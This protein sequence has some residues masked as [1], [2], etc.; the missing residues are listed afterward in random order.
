MLSRR[1]LPIRFKCGSTHFTLTG[2]VGGGGVRT[3]EVSGLE[4]GNWLGSVKARTMGGLLVFVGV[5]FLG[6]FRVEA[7]ELQRLKR[8][9]RVQPGQP[10]ICRCSNCVH[11]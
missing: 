8:L 7:R 5:K 6:L 3:R 2:G 1:Q 9:F 10:C 4:L 11:R